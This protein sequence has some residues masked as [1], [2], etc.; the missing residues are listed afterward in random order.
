[1][2]SSREAVSAMCCSLTTHRS[3]ACHPQLPHFF[4]TP[5]TTSSSTTPIHRHRVPRHRVHRMRTGGSRPRRTGRAAMPA[6]PSSPCALGS[7]R[8][9]LRVCL[10]VDPAVGTLLRRSSPARSVKLEIRSTTPSSARQRRGRR[11]QRRSKT[12]Q[13]SYHAAPCSVARTASAGSTPVRLQG[14]SHINIRTRPLDVLLPPS[15][16]LVASR[17][18]SRGS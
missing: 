6:Q 4:S 5:S 12:P 18:G 10:F 15:S 3:G 13:T 1:M 8:G 17:P 11:H 9:R 7:P 14:G 2:R 16:A